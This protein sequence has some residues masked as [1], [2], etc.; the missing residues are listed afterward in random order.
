M[1][2]DNKNIPPILPNANDNEESSSKIEVG[3]PRDLESKQ[4]LT[5][6]SSGVQNVM[7]EISK[8]IVGQKK[9]VKLLL[10]A[11][12]ADGHV[13]LE[14]FPGLAKTLTAKLTAKTI[15]TDFSRIQFTPIYDHSDSEPY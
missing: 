7:D 11:I 13:L 5:P 6:L 8:V 10:A 14:G 4:N 12:L 9:L 3:V 15:D 2:D 1:M